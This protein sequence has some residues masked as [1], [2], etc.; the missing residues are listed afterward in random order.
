[1]LYSVKDF[2]WEERSVDK[3][4]RVFCDDRYYYRGIYNQKTSMRRVKTMFQKGLIDELVKKEMTLPI[5]IVD[6]SFCDTDEFGMVLKCRKVQNVIFPTEW[7]FSMLLDAA[8]L[9]LDLGEV[10]LKYGYTL[11]DFHPYN[12]VF[13]GEKA[14]HVDLGS[15]VRANED[16]KKNFLKNMEQKYYRPLYLWSKKRKSITQLYLI[17]RGIDDKEWNENIYG[18]TVGNILYKSKKWLKVNSKESFQSF[19]E[20]LKNLADFERN[21][22]SGSQWDWSD[23]QDCYFHKDGRIKEDERFRIVAEFIRKYGVQKITELA[24]NQAVFSQMCIEKNIISYSLAIDYDEWAIDKA[25]RRL[26][27]RKGGA[28]INLGVVDIVRTICVDHTNSRKRMKNEGVVAMALLHHLILVQGLSMEKA[29]DIILEYGEKYAFVEFMPLGLYGGNRV[30]SAQNL[31]KTYTVDN[32]RK[33]FEERCV[34]KE[35]V[36][37]S[38]NRILFVGELKE[39]R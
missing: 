33:I 7:S 2:E 15:I 36:E 6:I 20:K 28:P 39:K 21:I 13:E 27:K 17:D 11:L 16:S 35:E 24:A 31:P 37:I 26:K 38:K 9:M 22:E 10:L 25:Y 12:I 30:V 34:L 32:F 23:Y 1:M 8:K 29:L 14:Y 3:L 5:E 19:K 4:G 18:I